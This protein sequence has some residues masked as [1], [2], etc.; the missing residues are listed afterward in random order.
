MR[1]RKRLTLG[2]RGSVLALRQATMVQEKIQ[3][4]FPDIQI[5]LEIIKTSG[6]KIKDKPLTDLGG[7]GL[8]TKEL[9]E[10]LLAGHIDLAVHSMKDVETFRPASL[11][12]FGY[13]ERHDPRDV[14]IS[15]QYKNFQDLPG[16]AKIGTCSPRR[17]AQVLSHRP[18][19]QIVPMRGNIDT[20]LRKLSV[21]DCDALILAYAG[22]QRLQLISCIT[23]VFEPDF[24]IPAVAQGVIG[25]EIRQGDDFLRKILEKINHTAT[26]RCV[27]IERE[28]LKGFEGDCRTA[29]AGWAH[30]KDNKI[31]F[32]GIVFLPQ[33][34]AFLKKELHGSY[35]DLV[36]QV[37]QLGQEFKLWHQTQ[38]QMT[39][40]SY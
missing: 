4:D 34:E 25:I 39:V 8:F 14:L 26:A 22:F 19:L 38:L 27:T 29:I 30:E 23:E 16:G 1:E 21:K 7:K 36:I 28:F 40:P 24:M 3:N 9:D 17:S 35:E 12:V 10:K 13:L 33:G 6:D 20:R 31:F 15:S 32:K 37:F 11:D 2:T 5:N 18:D